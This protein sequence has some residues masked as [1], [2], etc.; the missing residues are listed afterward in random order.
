M[1]KIEVVK[2]DKKVVTDVIFDSCGASCL[3]E[4]YLID[5][6]LNKD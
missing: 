3:V 2:I 6:P 1:D 4:K 5:N